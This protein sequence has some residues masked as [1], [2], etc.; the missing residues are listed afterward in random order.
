MGFIYESIFVFLW[1]FRLHNFFIIFIENIRMK[2]KA[3][4]GK[5]I[6]A[7]VLDWIV[8]MGF[9]YVLILFFGEESPDGT[10]SLKGGNVLLVPI[11]WFT[12]FVWLES[13]LE[14]T[15]SHRALNLKVI[16]ENGGQIIFIDSFKRHLLDPIDFTLNGIVAVICI[17]NTEKKQR[18]GDLFAK[19]RVI[20]INDPE[21][22]P[23]TDYIQI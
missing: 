12:Y 11:F 16:K 22:V 6:I 19:T 21:Q 10:M 1:L 14:G 4:L 5:R 20:D 3:N 8:L 13:I 7:T 17:Y 15:I 18:L 9:F 23:E 2:Y